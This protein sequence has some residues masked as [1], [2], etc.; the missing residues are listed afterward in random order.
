MN[1]D[2]PLEH[3]GERRI[4]QNPY[5]RRVIVVLFQECD[6]PLDNFLLLSGI[7]AGKR[8]VEDVIIGFADQRPREI[9]LLALER[10]KPLAAGAEVEVRPTAST[11]S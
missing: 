8:A 5:D 7:E 10:A 1:N 2:H 3:A 4:R 6:D 9:E 11:R